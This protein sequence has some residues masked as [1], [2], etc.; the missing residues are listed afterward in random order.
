LFAHLDLVKIHILSLVLHIGLSVVVAASGEV[1]AVNSLLLLLL[2]L[3]LFLLLLLPESYFGEDR[4]PKLIS[5]SSSFISAG[6]GR[7]RGFCCQQ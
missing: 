7:R 3:L 1:E 5:S 4:L 2:F 6:F